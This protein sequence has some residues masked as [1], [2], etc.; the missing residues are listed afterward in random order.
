MGTPL[1]EV[2]ELIGGGRSRSHHQGGA[3]GRGQRD[4][5][6]RPLDT[7][8]TYESLRA[9]GSGLGSAGSSCSTTR[10]T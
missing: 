3:V 8:V 1:R 7:P 9:I 6:R 2:I 5:H 10:P 4:H